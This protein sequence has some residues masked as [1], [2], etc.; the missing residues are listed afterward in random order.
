MRQAREPQ[1]IVAMRDRMLRRVLTEDGDGV[2]AVHLVLQWASD[3][4][5]ADMVLEEAVDAFPSDD[6]DPDPRDVMTALSECMDSGELPAV[7]SYLQVL[8]SVELD[9]LAAAARRLDRLC[10]AVRKGEKK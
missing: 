1:E 6:D 5:V 4:L 8:P 9:R 7:R 3:P 10:K 2:S